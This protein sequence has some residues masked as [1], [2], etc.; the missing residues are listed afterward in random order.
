MKYHPDKNPDDPEAEAKFKR[1]SEAYQVLYDPARRALYN[2]HGTA[3]ASDGIFADPD[4]FF[5]NQFGG[6]K[7]MDIIGEIS[8]AKDFGDAMRGDDAIS[9]PEKRMETRTERVNTLT[10]KLKAKLSLYTDAF[11]VQLEDS[12]P[13]GSTIN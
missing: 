3:Q 13:F 2:K 11:P 1:I 9:S 7:F 4:A 5:K 8:I 6:D 10:T 12:E